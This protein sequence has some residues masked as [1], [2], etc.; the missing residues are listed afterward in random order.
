[1]STVATEAKDSLRRWRARILV[2][3]W[4]AY[5]G[6]YFCRKAFYVVK[7]DLG[8]ELGLDA[9]ALGQLGMAYLVAYTLGQFT[10]AALG[11]RTGPRL[12]LLVGLAGSIAAN[13]AFGFANGFPTLFAFMVVNGFAQ[14][15]GW[16]ACIGT[17]AHWT[18]R[19][20][21]GW[22]L[23][24]WSTCY[25][26]GSVFASA[27]AAFWL[28]S[29]GFRGAFFAASAVLTLVWFVVLLFQR[30]GPEDVGLPPLEDDD[31][32]RE[33]SGESHSEDRGWTA[34]V[35]LNVALVG[36]FYFGVKFI[37]YA[38][39]SWT[40]YFLQKGYG[41]QGDEA[42]YLSTVFD[43]GGFLGVITAG[44]VSDK[45][46]ASRRAKV[47]FFMLL[48]MLGGTALLYFFGG[49]SV[50]LFSCCIALVG[51]MLYGPDALLT[52]AGAIDV[53]SRRVALQAAG[54]IN[55][56]GSVGSVVQEGVVARVWRGSD[57]DMVPVFVML[58][59]ASA[60]SVV[61]LAVVLVRNRRG[62][63]NL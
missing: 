15:T 29:Q 36:A 3:T 25:Q 7:G 26:L 19:S 2:S 18:R 41:L 56:M 5:G 35:A 46:F 50:V 24:L 55:G 31:A 44:F 9:A 14:A 13:L 4:V 6:L 54:V 48:G 57:G 51:F 52:G 11:A 45:L 30:D 12:L 59:V 37:R 34:E 17:L 27:W 63:A 33:A 42:G 28:A 20:E 16:P 40:P 47:A 61:A 8:D 1:M 60:L 58:F 38:L 21:R 62:R 39:W 49:V 22:M 32:P 43:V 23:G 10:S 53:G